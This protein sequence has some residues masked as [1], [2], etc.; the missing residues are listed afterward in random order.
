M[1]RADVSELAWGEYDDGEDDLNERGGMQLMHDTLDRVCKLEPDED[2]WR[3]AMLD[4]LWNGIGSWL[5]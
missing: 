2:S 4:R 5:A 3:E 1:I